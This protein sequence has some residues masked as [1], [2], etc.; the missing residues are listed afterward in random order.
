[1]KKMILTILGLVSVTAFAQPM[2]HQNNGVVLQ[3]GGLT[4]S[5]HTPPHHMQHNPPHMRHAPPPHHYRNDRYDR[6]NRYD[7]FERIR[8]VK[9]RNGDYQVTSGMKIQRHERVYLKTRGYCGIGTGY[10][11][12]NLRPNQKSGVMVVRDRECHVTVH[13]EK[14]HRR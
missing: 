12:I 10:A 5:T 3:I 2:H 14:G 1:M 6:N 8:V 9:E 4:V 7:D 11:S 13:K